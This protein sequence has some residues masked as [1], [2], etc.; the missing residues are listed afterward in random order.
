MSAQNVDGPPSG[1]APLIHFV[2]VDH[3]YASRDGQVKALEDVNLSIAEGQFVSIVGPS[4]CGKTT[5][6]MAIGGFVRLSSGTL[7]VADQP[8]DGPDPSRAVVF[9]ADSV[10]PWRTVVHNIEYGPQMRGVPASARRAEAQQLIDRVGLTGFEKRYP[11]DLSGG[12]RK[13]V[14]IARAYANNPRILLMDEPFGSVDAITR[15]ALQADLL[16]LWETERT[17][18]VFVTHDIEEAILLGDR[19]VVMSGRPGRVIADIDVPFPRPR[20][21]QALRTDADFVALRAELNDLLDHSPTA[22]T[23]KR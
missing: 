3:E 4:G 8:V 12:M 18:V 14:D 16:R 22:A 9:Q 5:L 1:A 17:T 21:P 6:M 2:G 10:F 15:D 11:R 13:R 20:D 23:P 7:R 19:V